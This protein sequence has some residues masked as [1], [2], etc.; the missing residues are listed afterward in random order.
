MS[1]QSTVVQ[2][3]INEVISELNSQW[4]N[5]AGTIQSVSNISKTLF[6][7]T[8]EIVPYQPKLTEV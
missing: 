1:L 5:L 7:K 4:G 6:L 2:L 8:K 3:C